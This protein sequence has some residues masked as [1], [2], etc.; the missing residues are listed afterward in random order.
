MSP[1]DAH[2]M[3]KALAT[4]MDDVSLRSQAS[5]AALVGARKFYAPSVIAKKYTK[6][7]EQALES[8]G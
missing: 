1:G 2:S 4:L 6:L 7:Y 5:R 8:N 3:A